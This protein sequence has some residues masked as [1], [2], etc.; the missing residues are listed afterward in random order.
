MR[1]VTKE[2]IERYLTPRW[3]LPPQRPGGD[4]GEVAA[5]EKGWKRRLIEG[6]D[7]NR[8]KHPRRS[9]PVHATGSTRMRARGVGAVQLNPNGCLEEKAGLAASE[10]LCAIQAKSK[11]MP[12]RWR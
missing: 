9:A 3:R 6:K 10:H 4:G 2:E 12:E 5:E 8:H 7:P 11:G 1:K